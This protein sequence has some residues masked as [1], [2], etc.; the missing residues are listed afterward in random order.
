MLLRSVSTKKIVVPNGNISNLEIDTSHLKKYGVAKA[1][2]KELYRIDGGMKAY[3]RGYFSSVLTY[4]PSSAL[5]W[6]FYPM[7]SNNLV[8]IFPEN[9]PHMLIQC[10]SG[11]LSGLTVAGL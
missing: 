6:M 9:T 8:T 10:A 11:S 4:V 3:Y 5:W 7:W 1:V 2:V